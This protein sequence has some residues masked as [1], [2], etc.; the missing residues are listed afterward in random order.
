[1]ILKSSIEV[2][3][4]CRFLLYKL[5]LGI[6]VEKKTPVILMKIKDFICYLN[7]QNIFFHV[8]HEI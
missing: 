4:H 3:I 6:S 8:F 5:S 1:M 7:N 2:E